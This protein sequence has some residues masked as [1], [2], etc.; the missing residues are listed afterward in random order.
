[1]NGWLDF[2]LGYLAAQLF[3][4]VLLALDALGLAS[5]VA[6]SDMPVL[7]IALLSV[8][9]GLATG[10]SSFGTALALEPTRRRRQR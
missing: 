6:H 9:L 3:L 10:V 1:M 2:I 8:F 4:A 7:P 5:R